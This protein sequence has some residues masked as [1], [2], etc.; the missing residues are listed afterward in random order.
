MTAPPGPTY[1]LLPSAQL[2]HAIEI[3]VRSVLTR[4]GVTHQLPFWLLAVGA[5]MI[6]M[7]FWLAS[8]EWRAKTILYAKTKPIVVIAAGAVVVLAALALYFDRES[9]YN[10]CVRALTE[11]GI[12]L[13]EYRCLEAS[14]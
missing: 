14:K 6:A 1:A 5:A 7:S 8:Q 10:Q 2:G 12:P 3:A 4:W 9:A 13:P 11:Q